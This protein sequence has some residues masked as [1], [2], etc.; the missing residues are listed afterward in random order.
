MPHGAVDPAVVY[1]TIRRHWAGRAVHFDQAPHHGLHSAAQHAA[2]L[3]Y[4][5]AWAGPALLDA[6]DVGCG[7][8]FFALLL[9]ELGH[10]VVGV[11]AVE[12]M[13][14]RA[15]AKARA[16]GLAVDLQRADAHALPFAHASFDLVIERHV[17]WTLA[18]PSGALREWARVLRPG[19]RLVLVEGNWGPPTAPSTLA[20]DYAGIRDALPLYGG[21][22]AAELVPRVRAAAL[23]AVS[24][25]PLM[26]AV[27][28]GTA[29]D[30]ERYALHARRPPCTHRSSYTYNHHI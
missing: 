22:P 25:E 23:I 12:E 3:T 19:G 7:T 21:R 29:P 15:R 17:L 11:D 9:A 1:E 24:I 5:R 2:W 30:R 14:D 6:L 28:W 4:V 20:T 18:D 10:R 13:L 26:D 27:L 8:G 16:A